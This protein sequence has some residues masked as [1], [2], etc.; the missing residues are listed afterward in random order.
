[1]KTRIARDTRPFLE[2]GS[3]YGVSRTAFRRFR[4]ADKRE[5]MLQW[6]YQNF[7]DPAERTPY[8]SAE[9]GY[10]WIWGGP[11]DARDE[12]FGK[13]GDL[14]PES[15]I[16][17]VADEVEK[18][19]LTLWAPT[20]N[21]DDYDDYD[22]P[23]EP[24]SL[25]IYLDE[26]SEAYGTARELEA[27]A[28][29]WEAL[30]EFQ[31]ILDTPRTIGIGHNRPPALLEP[32]EIKELRSAVV[33]LKKEFTKPTPA[34]PAVKRWTQSLRVALIAIAN[35]SARKFDKAVDALVV[36]GTLAVASHYSESLR[37]AFDAIL[38]WL[39]IAARHLF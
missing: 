35:W 17:E 8:E 19:G 18:D 1:M 2:D 12:L 36:A 9:G 6:F 14:V 13:F 20:A 34:I 31:K 11:N 32:E 15:F 29:A 27:R 28:K 4:K 24:P 16:D 39:E 37:K 23:S 25:D 30:D 3:Q 26:P 7:E 5:L 10:I 38:H 33:P 21:P 22:P